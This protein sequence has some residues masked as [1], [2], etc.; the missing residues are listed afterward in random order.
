MSFRAVQHATSRWV[1]RGREYVGNATLSRCQGSPLPGRTYAHAHTCL[2]SLLKHLGMVS[3][4]L[5]CGL[6]YLTYLVYT[7]GLPF[8]PQHGPTHPAVV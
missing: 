4:F 7:S 8:L 5:Y 6:I 1:K 3:V 2:L